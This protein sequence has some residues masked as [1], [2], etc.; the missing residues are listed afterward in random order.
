[1]R[2][3][4]ASSHEVGGRGPP[5]RVSGAY[6]TSSPSALPASPALPLQR[7]GWQR[8]WR[9]PGCTPT[10][11]MHCSRSLVCW[12]CLSIEFILAVLLGST[13]EP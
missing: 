3:V 1:M 11:L 7:P 9:E 13:R 2:L 5:P 8:R 6:D 10:C 4:H 12:M